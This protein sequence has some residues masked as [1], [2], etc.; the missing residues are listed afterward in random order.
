MF[1][2]LIVLLSLA[3]FTFGQIAN[4]YPDNLPSKKEKN[5]EISWFWPPAQGGW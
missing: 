1:V 3:I 5:G 2:R 4:L